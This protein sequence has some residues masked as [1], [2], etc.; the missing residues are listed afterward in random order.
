VSRE[1][2]S[3]SVDNVFRDGHYLNNFDSVKCCVMVDLSMLSDG[4]TLEF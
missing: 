2:A 1:F 4:C 3:Y